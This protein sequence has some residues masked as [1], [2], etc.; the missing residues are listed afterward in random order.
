M[1]ECEL[2]KAIDVDGVSCDEGECMYW[3]VI[4]H[5][6][7]GVSYSEGC[8][9]QYFGL[10]GDGNRELAAWLLSVKERVERVQDE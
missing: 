10:L 5:L 7:L 2:R 9:V 3:R 8:A 1:A 4:E 6:D